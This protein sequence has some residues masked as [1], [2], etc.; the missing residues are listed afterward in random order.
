MDLRFHIIHTFDKT[1]GCHTMERFGN[2]RQFLSLSVNFTLTVKKSNKNT[3]K[4]REI[5][6]SD[7]VG[8]LIFSLKVILFMMANGEL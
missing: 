2:F 8:T 5:D 6:Q 7:E 4:V 3:G 1:H